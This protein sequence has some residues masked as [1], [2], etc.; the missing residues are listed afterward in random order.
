M[1]LFIGNVSNTVSHSS[2][3]KH[4]EEVGKCEVKIKG[5]FAFADF[6]NEADGEVAIEKLQGKVIGGRKINIEYSKKSSKYIPTGKKNK[7][8]SRSPALKKRCYIC[9]SSS[10]IMKD[11]TKRKRSRSRSRRSSRSRRK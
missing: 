11:C 8:R 5:S 3:A 9:E 6:E 1:S 10:H 4:F 2:F 7:S